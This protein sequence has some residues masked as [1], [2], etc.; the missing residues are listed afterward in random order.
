KDP[1]I[2]KSSIL[3]EKNGFVDLEKLTE[4]EIKRFMTKGH[5]LSYAEN[6]YGDITLFDY[7]QEKE[8]KIYGNKI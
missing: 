6:M 1:P 8:L 3:T 4:Q 7:I 2:C 5:A